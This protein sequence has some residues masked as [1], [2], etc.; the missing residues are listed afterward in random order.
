MATATN[1]LVP[2]VKCST[3]LILQLVMDTFLAHFSPSLILTVI[4]FI[5]VTLPTFY[6]NYNP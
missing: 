2:K 5:F 4:S 1:F 3:P 6:V